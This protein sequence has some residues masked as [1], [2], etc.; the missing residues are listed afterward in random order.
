M[1][2]TVNQRG[3]A[4]VD[5]GQRVLRVT[6]LCGGPSA[7]REISLQSGHAV[8]EAL[9]RCGHRVHVA[10]IGPDRLEAL[11]HPTDVVFPALH[12]AFGEDGT[13][14]RLMAERGLAF[15]GSEA[16]ASALA[17]D[18]VA[19]KSLA[20]A[21]GILTPR[22]ELWD[23]ATLNA[24]AA[25]QLAVP[26]VVKPVDQGSSVATSLVR[27][28][29][30][31]LPA[32]RLTIE[33]HKRALVEQFIAGEELTVGL[34]DGEPLPVICIRPKRPF[35]DF[36]AKYRDDATEYLF[37]AGYSASLLEHAQMLSR[38]V[39]DRVGCRHLARV[40]WIVDRDGR[41]WLLEVNTLPGF[42]GHSLVPK[43]AARA[44]IPFEDLVDRLV[45]MALRDVS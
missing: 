12:G 5:P 7:E 36:E 4:V 35:Y 2:T 28:M 17:M 34:L 39:F 41:L 23:T 20:S 26:L 25:P 42:T 33:H 32:V 29:A 9:Q 43:A 15:V 14:Q 31:F 30:E 18:K 45:R 27:D 40:D 24:R 10:D 19:T 8:A 22:F 38:Q 21:A 6:V 11:D 44:G 37:D 3:S 16:R 1:S 13:V